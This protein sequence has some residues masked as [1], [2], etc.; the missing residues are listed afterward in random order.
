MKYTA[1]GNKHATMGISKNS[2]CLGI[3]NFIFQREIVDYGVRKTYILYSMI[4]NRNFSITK[5][6]SKELGDKPNNN[7]NKDVYIVPD[8]KTVK[9]NPE[10]EQKIIY[11]NIFAMDNILAAFDLVKN[12]K[13]TGV[14]NQI[15]SEITIER[16]KKLQKDLKTQKYSPKPSRKVAIPKPNGGQRF[17]GVASTIDKVVQMILVQQ[18]Q[19]IFEPKFSEY[20]Y[21]FRPKRGCHDVL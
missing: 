3:R 15:K 13:F 14:D 17:L 9:C 4:L 11:A 6:N 5:E 8:L 10:N 7:N 12:K 19:P 20:S 18:L 21:G 2:T 16:L 1:M